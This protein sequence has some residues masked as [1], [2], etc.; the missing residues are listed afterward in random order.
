MASIWSRP[1]WVKRDTPPIL[2]I[3]PCIMPDVS[4]QFY[5]HPF[6]RFPVM[7]STGTQTNKQTNKQRWKH[8]L[9]R[10]AEVI[11]QNTIQKPRHNNINPGVEAHSNTIC[12]FQSHL[13]S[14][15]QGSFTAWEALAKIVREW[16]WKWIRKP[17][18]N[19]PVVSPFIESSIS[20]ASL[21]RYACIPKYLSH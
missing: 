19:T 12:S 3:V 7:L 16:W 9:R 13:I 2:Q 11:M 4:W 18:Y 10:S 21:R 5:E 15:Q 20:N 8:N 17:E 1:Q 6:T 14:Y